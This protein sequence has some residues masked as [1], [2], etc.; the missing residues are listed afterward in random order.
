M[1]MDEG[2]CTCAL[3]LEHGAGIQAQERASCLKR[4]G[5]GE[6]EKNSGPSLVG[7]YSGWTQVTVA[8]K[9]QHRYP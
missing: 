5:E 4:G 9:G 8:E 2:G 7:Y 1:A 6:G 3:G